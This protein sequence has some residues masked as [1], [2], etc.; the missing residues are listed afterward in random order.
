MYMCDRGIAKRDAQ[1]LLAD[2]QSQQCKC[3]E[4]PQHL[5]TITALLLVHA[6]PMDLLSL[7]QLSLG[8]WGIE[9]ERYVVS[10]PGVGSFAV[11]T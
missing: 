2:C 5:H 8:S 9:L 11:T 10:E 1:K 7:I 4:Q 3:T 6:L